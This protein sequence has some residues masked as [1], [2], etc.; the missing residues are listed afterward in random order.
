M[1]RTLKLEIRHDS[2]GAS[3]KPIRNLYVYFSNF[4][5]SFV[6]KKSQYFYKIIQI[7][8]FRNTFRKEYNNFKF[9]DN[10]DI[11]NFAI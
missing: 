2:R 3:K 8:S 4:P 5:S 7:H 10:G 9:D 11:L 6:K 1:S